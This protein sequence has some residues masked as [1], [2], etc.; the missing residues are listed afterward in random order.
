V[1]QSIVETR[2][3]SQ[4]CSANLKDLLLE[5]SALLLSFQAINFNWHVLSMVMVLKILKSKQASVKVGKQ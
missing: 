5:K 3:S 1:Q 2:T 4:K